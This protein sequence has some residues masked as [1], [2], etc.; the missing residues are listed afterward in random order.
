MEGKEDERRRGKKKER[1]NFP[2]I[3]DAAEFH[4]PSHE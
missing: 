4:I 2:H 3:T 1:N